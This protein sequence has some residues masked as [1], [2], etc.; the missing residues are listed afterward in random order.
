MVGSLLEKGPGDFII[1]P[2]SLKAEDSSASNK[3]YA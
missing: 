2:A 1:Y 3:V